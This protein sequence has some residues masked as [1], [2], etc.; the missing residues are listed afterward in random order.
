MKLP[1]TTSKL[2]PAQE[3]LYANGN[4]VVAECVAKDPVIRE[5]IH[6]YGIYNVMTGIREAEVR[7]L[8]NA[9]I[10]CDYIGEDA[11]GNEEHVPTQGELRLN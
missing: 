6:M 5:R 4:F 8:N 11:A 3:I 9:K 1:H 7:R 2:E 10:V